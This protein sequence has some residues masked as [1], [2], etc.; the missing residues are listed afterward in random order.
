[1]N[2]NLLA[3]SLA[4]FLGL[5]CASEEELELVGTVERTSL[6]LAAPVS[7]E[8]VEIGARLGDRVHEGQVV[9]QLDSEVAEAEQAAA[10][11]ALAAEE[12]NLAAAERELGRF[13]GLSKAKVASDANLDAARRL[14]EETRARVAERRARL[15]QAR[16]RLEDLSIRARRDG[17]LDQLPFDVGERAPA[18][19]V[20]AVVLAD[21]D[22]W[23]RLWLPAHLIPRIARE[24]RAE[25]TIYGLGRTLEGQ[26][27]DIAREPEYTPHYALTERQSAH[28]VFRARLRLLQ[29]PESVRPGLAASVK[30]ALVAESE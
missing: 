27:E 9:V 5:G 14:A 11:A 8:I 4:L 3:V 29:A 2:S 22:P 1:M 16:K 6:E 19:G 10:A 21:E 20:V 25:V 24:A 7:E 13:E 17:L 28:L 15:A 23:V 12:A 30:L 18:G 26:L